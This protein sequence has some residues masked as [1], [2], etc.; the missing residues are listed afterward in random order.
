MAINRSET[1]KSVYISASWEAHVE[2]TRHPLYRSAR[3]L[4]KGALDPTEGYVLDIGC[5]DLVA[6]GPLIEEGYTVLGL[7]LDNTAVRQAR[8]FYPEAHLLVGNIEALPLNIPKET[9]KVITLLDILE[10]LEW[11][12]AVG[13]LKDIRGR[14]GRHALIVSMPNVSPLSIHTLREGTSALLHGERPATGLFDR[15]H[16]ILT[17]LEGHCR[18]FEEAGYSVRDQF[19]SLWDGKTTVS[20]SWKWQKADSQLPPRSSPLSEAAKRSYRLLGLR[21]GP[22]V[23]SKISD[24]SPEQVSARINGYQG[25]YLLEPVTDEEVREEP[26]APGESGK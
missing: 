22:T 19:V 8:K 18:L 23:L 24:L 9:P 7:D 16:K 17:G 26:I 1:G 15:T 21:I 13:A 11:D 4:V 3:E 6:V 10:H 20:G 25:L 2:R 14:F 12:D 5:S